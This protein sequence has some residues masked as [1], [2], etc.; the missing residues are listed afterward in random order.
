[1]CFLFQ[2]IEKIPIFLFKLNIQLHHFELSHEARNPHLK[3]KLSA[4][5]ITIWTSQT[6]C[7][8]HSVQVAESSPHPN[9]EYKFSSKTRGTQ[10]RN[11]ARK[12]TKTARHLAQMDK[13]V[14]LT[15][16]V[17]DA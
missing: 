11:K 13:E 17:A 1:M 3:V 5:P 15:P 12:V 6:N 2:N 10:F 16:L 8:S 7:L 4:A 9:Q 14:K